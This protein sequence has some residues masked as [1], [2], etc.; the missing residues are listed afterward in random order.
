ML[1]V[2]VCY[3]ATALLESGLRETFLWLDCLR[4]LLVSPGSFQVSRL[5]R[6]QALLITGEWVMGLELEL[7][8]MRC[9]H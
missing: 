5:A 1:V 8:G 3:T 9:R 4:L 7:H 2:S 6:R